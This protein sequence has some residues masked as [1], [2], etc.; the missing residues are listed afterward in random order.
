MTYPLVT[1]MMLSH[2]R[3]QFIETAISCFLSQTYPNKELVI[4]DSLEYRIADLL[5]SHPR[6]TYVAVPAATV[7]GAKRNIACELAKGEII[8]SMDDDDWSSP[9]RI[10]SQM[11]HLNSS[12]VQLVGYHT[13]LWLDEE[14]QKAYSL[15]VNHDFC[16]GQS[17]LFKRSLWSKFPYPENLRDSED[18]YMLDRAVEQGVLMTVGGGDNLVVRIHSAALSKRRPISTPYVEIPI[19][20]IPRGAFSAKQV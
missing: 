4:V 8:C 17:F 9:S 6:L 10:Q 1:V 7:A 15:Y 3:R 20:S 5:P 11:E 16:P 18:T 19:N 12:W 2:N 14:E 13:T